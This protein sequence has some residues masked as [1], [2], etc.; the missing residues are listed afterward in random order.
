[1][2]KY[3]FIYFTWLLSNKLQNPQTVMNC[4]VKKQWCNPRGHGLGLER[5]EDLKKSW[6]WYKVFGL[7]LG[8]DK[9]IMVL[10][11]N[12]CLFQDLLQLFFYWLF[13]FFFFF[14]FFFLNCPDLANLFIYFVLALSSTIIVINLGLLASIVQL[15]PLLKHVVC[16]PCTSALLERVKISRG[17]I[18]LEPHGANISDLVLCNL[19]SK[20]N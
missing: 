20:C 19:M 3:Q 6:S 5:L 14:F 11:Q 15:K 1:M 9:M 8:L 18:L 4:F 16:G 7:D 10:R 12:S 2:L 13:K 17:G